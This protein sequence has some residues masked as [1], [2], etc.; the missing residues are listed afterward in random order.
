M[1]GERRARSHPDTAPGHCHADTGPRDGCADANARA[2]SD[3]HANG[4]PA[5]ANTDTNARGRPGGCCDTNPCCYAV[6]LEDT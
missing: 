2:D 6:G 3:G 4:R 5:C 1:H